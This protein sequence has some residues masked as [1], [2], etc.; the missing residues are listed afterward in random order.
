[1]M[2]TL[3]SSPL[4]FVCLLPAIRA[5]DSTPVKV[6][7]VVVDAD[8]SAVAGAEFA[9]T[10]DWASGRWRG[11]LH[12]NEPDAKS[13]LR[14]AADG[15]LRGHWM[16]DLLDRPLLGWSA[17]QRLVAIVAPS[18]TDDHSIV[19]HTQVVLRPAVLLRGRG[20]TD[21][22][23]SVYVSEAEGD[24]EP[25]RFGGRFG[26]CFTFDAPEFAIPLPP[27]RYQ[28][29][30]RAG[31]SRSRTRTLVL[32]AGRTDVD[33]GP[34]TIQW[35]PFDLLGEVLPDWELASADNLPLAQASLASFRG[36]PLL[37]V[38]DEWGR[39]LHWSPDLRQGT[40]D[41]A[42]HARR[43]EFAVVLFD[44]STRGALPAE[45]PP[46]PIVERTLP[47]LRPV[48]GKN[49]DTLY[50]SNYAIVVLDADGR[51]RHCDRDLAGAIAVLD[52][53]LSAG[54]G[55]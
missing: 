37:C 45:P 17:D 19:V 6:D 34:F 53:L 30:V 55:K 50:G 12:C 39:T 25:T 42:R 52:E 3:Q 11:S 44:T 40:A 51:L 5:Q 18:V 35:Q 14:S 16:M 48:P 29:T 43:A 8:G 21:G 24:P 31:L 4:L 10:W 28:V 49:A 41:L 54:G 36:K 20:K 1:M 23:V 9:D 22:A 15:A 27:G 38:F 13:P 33:A 26:Y 7:T 32:P 47:V 46:E 2:R